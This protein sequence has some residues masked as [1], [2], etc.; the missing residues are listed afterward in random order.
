MQVRWLLTLFFICCVGTLKSQ[1]I[2]TDSFTVESGLPNDFV[3]LSYQDRHG[4]LWISTDAGLLR[5]DGKRMQQFTMKDGLPYNEIIQLIEDP[6]GKLWVQSSNRKIAYF[7]DHLNRFVLP[8]A[9]SNQFREEQIM[10][11]DLYGEGIRWIGK[12]GSFFLQHDS[13]IHYPYIQSLDST[14]VFLMLPQSY[15]LR[16]SRTPISGKKNQDPGL[17]KSEHPCRQN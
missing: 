9:L 8:G 13:L 14:I 16:H 2:L 4:F 6:E 1:H 10:K 12:T 11:L 15:E 17:F 5:Y 7:V 3:Y